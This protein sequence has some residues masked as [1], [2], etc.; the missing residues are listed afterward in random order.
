MLLWG[1]SKG[2]E[3]LMWTNLSGSKDRRRSNYIVRDLGDL[4]LSESMRVRRCPIAQTLAYQ[5]LDHH[6]KP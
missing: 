6:L 2:G 1:T 5:F 4:G 3:T